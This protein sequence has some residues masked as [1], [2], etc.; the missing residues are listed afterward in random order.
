[1]HVPG[2]IVDLALILGTAAVTTIL[3]KWLRQPVVLGYIIAGFLVS[4]GFEF[5]P[6]VTDTKSIQVWAEIGVIFLLFSLGLEFSFKKLLKVGGGAAVTGIFEI[7]CMLMLGYGLGQWLGLNFINSLFLGG[8]VAISSTTII[9]RAFHEQNVKTNQ[10][11]QLVMGVLI[12]ED[13]VAVL[14]MVLLS[15][16]SVSQQFSGNDLIVSLSKFLILLVL[17]FLLGIFLIPT[18]LKKLSKQMNNETLLVLSLALC[19]GMVVLAANAGFSPALGAFIMGSILAETTKA[20]HIEN[21][22]LSIKDLFGAVFFVSVGLLL[23]P[24]LILE[25]WQLVLLLVFLVMIGK[26]ISVSLGALISGRSLKQAIQAGTSMSQIGE[27]SFIIASLGVSLKVTNDYLYPVAVGVSVI[28]TFFTPYLMKLALPLHQ[29]LNQFLP[30]K[31]LEILDRYSSGTQIIQAESAWSKVLKLYFQIIGINSII[32]IAIIWLSVQYLIPLTTQWFPSSTLLFVKAVSAVLT[33]GIMMP[34]IWALTIKRIRSTAYT[35]LWLDKKYNKGPLVMLE[36]IRNLFSIIF[37]I[38][39][40]TQYFSFY[41]AIPVA[42]VVLTIVWL[43]FRK[44]LER[45]YDRLE[46]RFINNLNEKSKK[47]DHHKQLIP[48]DAHLSTFTVHA[49]ALC[50]GKTLQQLAWREQFGINVAFIERGNQMIYAPKRDVLIF[51]NDILGVIG[52]DEQLKTYKQ[53][54]ETRNIEEIVEDVEVE[55]EK[56]QLLKI[57]VDEHT[58]LKGLSIKDSGIREKT[59]GLVVGIERNGERILNPDSNFVFEWDDIVWIVGNK[60]LIKKM[61]KNNF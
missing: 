35:E 25:Y 4:Q 45:F 38:I 20:H 18:L 31:W 50:V 19:F 55:R 42:L 61:Y 28:T 8:I 41:I 26:T 49:Q 40:I 2:L 33:L 13:V 5:L 32:I 14:L 16:I 30:K 9:L 6:S 51:P 7:S 57:V 17:W 59:Q 37:I 21:L 15:T 24:S 43:V 1:M 56:I 3:F 27:F 47:E 36:V 53:F 12:V 22:L 46:K 58:K 34:F 60:I 39:L 44:K 52:G 23:N 48:W 10:F 54:I 11:A 29:Q